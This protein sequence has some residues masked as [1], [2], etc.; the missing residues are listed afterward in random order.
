MA[1]VIWIIKTLEDK[2]RNSLEGALK[3]I[4]KTGI[5]WLNK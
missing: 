1:K 3:K 2:D 5:Q 4:V